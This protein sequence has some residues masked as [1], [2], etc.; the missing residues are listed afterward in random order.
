LT[1]H[2]NTAQACPKFGS[3]EI[4]TA[5]SRMPLDRSIHD[6]FVERLAARA[7]ATIPGNP[8]DPTTTFGPLA[9][10][11]QFNK[12]SEYVQYGLDDGVHLRAGGKPFHPDGL[13]GKGY[14]YLPTVFTDATNEM[15][16][17][18]DEIFG[19]VLTVIPFSSEWEAI[20]LANDTDYGLASGIHTLNLKRAHRVARAMHAGTVWVNIYNMF[21]ATTPFGGYKSSG[22]GREGGPEVME[23]YTQYKSVWIDLS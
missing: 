21:D 1:P 12:V 7:S 23:N 19:P 10:A 16:I 15:R 4:C 17:A 13:D 6:E 9:A 14:Y 20:Q 8:L 18:R 2:R 3:G 11:S 5:G 22:F